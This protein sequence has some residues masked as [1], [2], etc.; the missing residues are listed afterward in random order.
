MAGAAPRTDTGSVS[1]QS[2]RPTDTHPASRSEPISSSVSISDSG[3]PKLCK[4]VRKPCHRSTRRLVSHQA[5]RC[6]MVDK[7]ETY[8]DHVTQASRLLLDSTLD[9]AEIRKHLVEPM[10]WLNSL[11]ESEKLQIEPFLLSSA[12][13]A[14]SAMYVHLETRNRTEVRLA[15][16]RLRQSLN[17][18][19]ESAEVGA[20]RRPAEIVTWIEE[21]LP[22]APSA[23]LARLVGVGART[24]QR[25]ASQDSEPSGSTADRIRALA[26]VL[27]HL[28]HAYTAAGCLAWL[29][30]PHPQLDGQTPA[31]VLRDPLREREVIETAAGSRVLTAA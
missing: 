12:L 20:T 21:L 29:E 6:D 30:R 2:L 22:N 9:W 23:T 28:R 18:I 15:V 24:W 3:P 25:W 27:A 14:T 11:T 1:R 10:R 19:A 7:A 13:E 5:T 17:D 8:A 16:E 26:Q 4:S 31:E